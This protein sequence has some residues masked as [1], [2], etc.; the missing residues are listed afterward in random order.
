MTSDKQSV[1][2][3]LQSRISDFFRASPMGDIERNI[4]ALVAQAF[5]RMDLVTHD[6]FEIQ[7]ALIERLSERVEALER[8][9]QQGAAG[10]AAAGVAGAT[11]RQP[12]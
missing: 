11:P 10:P 5:Q 4:K 2:N 6:E 9:V 3:D 1:L 12:D 7:N 8:Q